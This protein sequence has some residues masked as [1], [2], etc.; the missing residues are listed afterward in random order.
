MKFYYGSLAAASVL[1]AGCVSN[2]GKPD[3]ARTVN[4]DEPHIVVDAHTTR[5]IGGVS[6][7]DRK[8]YFAVSD[9]GTGFDKR[10][11]EDIYDY[12]VH[13]L[14]ISFGRSLGPVQ[15][16]ASTLP[17]DP[18]RPGYADTT[19]LKKQNLPK[20]GK[21]F[22]EDF[23]PN[24]DVAAHGNHN[25]Y[26]AYMGKHMQEGA[27]YHGTPEW[28]PENIDA[29]AQLAADIF[30]HNYTDFDRPKYFEPLNEPHWKYFVDPHLADWHLAVQE[31][32]HE[33]TP[34]VKVG[35]MCQSVSYF[36]RDNYQ[37]FNGFK[38][39]I[40]NTDA[41]M[42]FYSFHSYDYFKWEDDDFRGRV[43]SG[44]ALEGSLDLMQNFTVN[45]FGKEVDVVVSEQGGYINVQPKGAYDG[46]LLAEELAANYFND[47]EPWERELK[48]RSIVAFVHVSSI[49]ANTMAFI[50]HPDTVQKSVP[51]L[52]PNTWAWDTKY[53]AS[54][55]VPK[56]YTD[57]ET[58]VETHMLDFYKFFRGV[59]GR[60]VKALVNDPD[61]QT[62]AFVDGSTL[63]LAVNNQ[64]WRP[65]SV[66]LY[67]IEADQV[68][69]RK[70][71]RNDD[72]TA[73]FTEETVK[74][75]ETLTL[76]GREAVM[77]VANLGDVIEERAVVNEIACYGDKTM[78]PLKKATFTIKVPVDQEI[79]YA[80]LRVGLTRKTDADKNAIITLNGETLDVPLEDAA[81]RFSK[82]EY[83]VTKLVNIDP[84]KLKA[85]NVVTVSFADSDE[86][87][88]GTAVIRA[89]V[90]K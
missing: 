36:F 12:L 81:D 34:E 54:L 56:N 74:T 29:A 43:Q 22:L 9:N 50:D 62:R 3:A 66:N 52:L 51:F 10:M 89:A 82:G 13:D 59:N 72:Y 6:E 77:I 42:D 17:E 78:V 64:S 7:V 27:D 40:K 38:G 55:Y 46:E 87:Y 68:E 16:T 45:T 63:Y 8:A 73:Y 26:P 49:L 41:N 61:L 24:L 70:F 58:W 53:Y 75:P 4:W 88:V 67:G 79:E 11:P 25:A 90:R 33:V 48:K 85:E 15:Y 80:Q 65:E 44:I 83:G 86:G 30:L 60:R 1:A 35:G 14:G 21:Q 32:L 20:P 31:K 76:R 28:I 39:F 71:G 37:N 69:I 18:N 23:G 84:A 57:K 47:A 2:D 5:E 19:K